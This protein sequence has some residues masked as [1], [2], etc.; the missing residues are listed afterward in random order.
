MLFSSFWLFLLLVFSFNAASQAE[1][2][3]IVLPVA[4]Q[5]LESSEPPPLAAIASSP[6]IGN[7]ASSG[8][9][10]TSS[11]SSPPPSLSLP[12][13]S[14]ASTNVTSTPSSSPGSSSGSSSFCR[15]TRQK[16]KAEAPMYYKA[17]HKWECTQ[18]FRAALLEQVMTKAAVI[19]KAEP[20][21]EKIGDA[22]KVYEQLRKV[23]NEEFFDKK[24]A[25]ALCREEPVES[26][27][28]LRAQ[29]R[30]AFSKLS[31]EDRVNLCDK[32][33]LDVKNHGNDAALKKDLQM[34]KLHLQATMDARSSRGG[35][36]FL[37][38]KNAL[39][40]YNGS[41]L[42]LPTPQPNMSLQA[43]VAFVKE[44]KYLQTL[45]QEFCGHIEAASTELG[46]PLV[47][48]SASM[49]LCVNT[50]EN[51]KVIRTHL[52]A[53]VSN[54]WQMY[55]A[56]VQTSGFIFKSLIPVVSTN[57]VPGVNIT[58]S[59]AIAS[60]RKTRGRDGQ[61]N[62]IHYYLQ[63]EGKCG[64]ILRAGNK[65]PFTGYAVKAS[66][67][68]QWLQ[69]LTHTYTSHGDFIVFSTSQF[70]SSYIVIRNSTAIFI[71]SI[72]LACDCL[73]LK[74]LNAAIYIDFDGN[75][76]FTKECFT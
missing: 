18:D 46:G 45:F 17:C 25:R 14:P 30:L 28:A 3:A 32:A 19:D 1:S 52:H 40:T 16:I 13:S 54:N 55:A 21:L 62:A 57:G 70:V 58:S 36:A 35:K 53:G 75:S 10:V 6:V 44:Q 41:R 49:E 38:S 50:W 42:V 68:T 56:T 67:I 66:W 51:E 22:A 71:V 61:A 5:S 4:A 47:S 20:E 27:R 43:V 23:F 72:S 63:C 31:V 39:F 8:Q 33:L 9:I 69:A 73:Y 34:K 2:A 11:V 15:R 59:S 74:K 29:A 64:S 37:R 12:S 26:V 60:S 76:Y 7:A 48:W 65:D 24:K